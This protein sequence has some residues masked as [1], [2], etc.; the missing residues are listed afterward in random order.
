MMTAAFYVELDG[1]RRCPEGRGRKRDGYGQR[2]AKRHRIG[3]T[4]TRKNLRRYPWRKPALS[5][6]GRRIAFADRAGEIASLTSLLKTSALVGLFGLLAFFGISLFL[7][8]W[9]LRPLEK[10]WRQ[11]RQ[12]VADASHELKTPLTVILAN[13]GIVLSHRDETVQSQA[14]W[15]EYTQTEATH[16]KELVGSRCSSHKRTTSGRRSRSLS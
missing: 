15:L 3:R 4:R 6:P 10:S 9:A 14:K 1:R 13:M 8:R 12:F 7:A 11:Q 2:R 5:H 16:M